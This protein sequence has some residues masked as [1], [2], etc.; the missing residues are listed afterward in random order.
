MNFFSVPKSRYHGELG[1]SRKHDPDIIMEVHV[2]NTS[3]NGCRDPPDNHDVNFT[4]ESRSIAIRLWYRGVTSIK[5]VL[6][7]RPKLNPLVHGG[8][9]YHPSIKDDDIKG[10]SKNTHQNHL[11]VLEEQVTHPLLPLPRGSARC[12]EPC[13]PHRPP[14]CT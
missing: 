11:L 12:S 1:S 3:T 7:Q 5:L 9:I 14:T 8:I 4:C 13:R 2:W 10:K 6:C